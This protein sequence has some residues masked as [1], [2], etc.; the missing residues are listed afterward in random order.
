L[1]KNGLI[2]HFLKEIKGKIGGMG[3][4]GRKVSSYWITVKRQYA[5]K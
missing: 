4:R 3:R 1:C 2:K 5:G